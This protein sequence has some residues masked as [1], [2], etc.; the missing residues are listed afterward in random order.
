MKLSDNNQQRIR[1]ALGY[2]LQGD[3]ALEFRT[4]HLLPLKT[5][6]ELDY[7]ADQVDTIEALL[8]RLDTLEGSLDGITTDSMAKETDTLKL[9][10]ISHYRLLNAR[11][12]SLLHELAAALRVP[13]RKNRYVASVRRTSYRSY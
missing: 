8:S 2:G 6:F 9:D 5:A 10:W 3:S 7:T 4:D 1:S 12:N 13:I 11:G